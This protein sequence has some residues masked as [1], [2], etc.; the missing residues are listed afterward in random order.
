MIID[1]DKNY[2][3]EEFATAFG[4]C[5]ICGKGNKFSAHASDDDLFLICTAE[6]E[7]GLCFSRVGEEYAN[8]IAYWNFR[9]IYIKLDHAGA[10]LYSVNYHKVLTHGSK[11]DIE[12][13]GKIIDKYKVLT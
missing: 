2:G 5:P 13:I 11:I 1:F 9:Q 10:V 7:C 8:V 6:C 4:K 12:E 3:S